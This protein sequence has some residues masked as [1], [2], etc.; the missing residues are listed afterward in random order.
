[1]IQGLHYIESDSTFGDRKG[2]SLWVFQPLRSN[3]TWR[4][5]DQQQSLIEKQAT[6]KMI[7]ASHLL[8]A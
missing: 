4:R 3:Q 6:V 1:M 5:L 8:R 2:Q 7:A